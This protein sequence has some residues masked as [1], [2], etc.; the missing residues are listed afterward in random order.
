MASVY[1]RD[2][3][4]RVLTAAGYTGLAAMLGDAVDAVNVSILETGGASAIGGTLA[5]IGTLVA[6]FIG[7]RQT[8]SLD[9]KVVYG[10]HHRHDV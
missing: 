9:P 5:F 7:D 6:R 10:K 1:W 3:V 8:A 4:E 2:V